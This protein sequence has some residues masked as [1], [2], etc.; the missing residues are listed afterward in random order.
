MNATKDEEPRPAGQRFSPWRLWPAALIG[1]GF[2]A[3]FALG[4][5]DYLSFAALSEHRQQLLAWRADNYLLAVA[6]FVG[7]YVLTAAFSVPG[8]MWLSIGGGFLFGAVASTLYVVVGATLGAMAV[9]LAARHALGDYLRS[10]AGPSMRKMEAGFRDNALSYLLVLRLVPLF[11]F[12]LVNLVPAFLGVP[13]RIFAIGTF[14]GI[15]P[16]SF[17]YAM[18]GNGLGALFDSGE[19]PDLGI[20]FEPE[21]LGPIVGL[22]VLSLIPVFYKMYMAAKAR[23]TS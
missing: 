13:L 16:G 1:A 12:W 19:M 4:L 5:D 17:V 18:V 21:I 15:I 10:K 14:F 6:C 7:V 20:I 22:A 2:A 23:E 11:P 9:F 8:A 3:F